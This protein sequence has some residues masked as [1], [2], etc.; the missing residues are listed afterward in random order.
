LKKSGI[1]DPTGV[2]I[3]II[4]LVVP[5][6]PVVVTASTTSGAEKIRKK[7][8]LTPHNFVVTASTTS[9][10]EKNRKTKINFAKI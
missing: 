5:P 8:L 7:P 4:A 9:G 10:A 3:A 6:R 2:L 1:T